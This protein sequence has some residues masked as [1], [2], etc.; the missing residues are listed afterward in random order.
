MTCSK[1]S[2]YFSQI[3]VFFNIQ[4]F[5]NAVS[6]TH[7][8]THV[9]KHLFEKRCHLLFWAISA[10]TTIWIVFPGFHCFGQKIAKTQEKHFQVKSNEFLEL[11]RTFVFMTISGSHPCCIDYGTFFVKVPMAMSWQVPS[12]SA[13]KLECYL[14]TGM[15]TML[16]SISIVVVKWLEFGIEQVELNEPTLPKRHDK[17]S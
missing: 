10:E 3:F 2:H 1:T 14:R 7:F 15:I 11:P 12:C 4:L 8:F 5:K 17:Y 9:K 6:K 13:C 16:S